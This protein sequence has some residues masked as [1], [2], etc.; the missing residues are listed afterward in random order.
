MTCPKVESFQCTNDFFLMAQTVSNTFGSCRSP[1][2]QSVELEMVA[3]VTSSD[4]EL[5]THGNI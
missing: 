5:G 3:R 4:P 2:C 1:G